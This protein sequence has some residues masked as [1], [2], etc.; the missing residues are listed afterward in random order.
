MQYAAVETAL[1]YISQGARYMLRGCGAKPEFSILQDL[2]DSTFESASSFAF[3]RA[4]DF[5]EQR[6][7][8]RGRQLRGLFFAAG[9][10]GQE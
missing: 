3:E 7:Q 1:I 5:Q 2:P 6:Q 4:R 9:S 8:Q 10:L